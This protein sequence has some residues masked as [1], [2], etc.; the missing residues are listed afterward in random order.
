MCI[1]KMNGS[2][3]GVYFMLI[4]VSIGLLLQNTP[5]VVT[6]TEENELLAFLV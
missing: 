1:V 2:G 3:P 4:N 6:K 5:D